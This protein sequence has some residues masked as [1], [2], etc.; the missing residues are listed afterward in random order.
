[1]SARST[2]D[3]FHRRHGSDLLAI[4]IVFIVYTATLWSAYA[5]QISFA[6]ALMGGASN[7]LPVVICGVVARRI[8]TQRIIGR[9]L[10]VQVIGHSILCALFSLT[11]Y[12]ILIV[13]LAATSSASLWNFVVKNFVVRGMSWQMLENVT[14]YGVLAALT[15][16]RA[17]GQAAK[18][19]A[20]SISAEHVGMPAPSPKEPSRYLV[21]IGDEFRPIDVDRI[22]SISG[23]DDYTELTTL[24]GKR[25]VTMTLAEFEATLDPVRFIRIHRSRIVNLDYVERAEPAGSGRLL[26]HMQNGDTIATSRS[27]GRAIKTRVI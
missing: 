6:S 25:L 9:G 1:M 20:D 23:A 17:Y 21:R 18:S 3:T 11:A 15:Y 26:L 22:V 24:D 12:W 10:V 7:T 16:A 4:A 27:G 14:T 5:Y 2:L 13:L 19:A 8:I